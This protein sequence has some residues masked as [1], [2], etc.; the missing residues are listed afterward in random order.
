MPPEV[1]AR[2][3]IARAER[4]LPGKPA[5]EGECDPRWQ[6]I[7]EVE[8][9]VDSQPEAVWEFAK[10]WGKHPQQDLRTAVGVCLVEALLEQHFELLFPRVREAVRAS[11]RL[12]DTFSRAWWYG[13]KEGSPQRDAL[14]KLQRQCRARTRGKRRK[15]RRAT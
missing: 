13:F 14:E 5:P 11:S 6:A 3:A 2:R 4:I 7:I 1:A 10:R 15:P 12:A 8:T 9:F